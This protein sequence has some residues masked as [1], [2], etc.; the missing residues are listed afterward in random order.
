MRKDENP[1]QNLGNQLAKDC[2]GVSVTVDKPKNPSGVWFLD[3][4]RDGHIVNVQWQP[5]RGFG[6][7]S[8]PGADYGEGADEIYDDSDAVRHRVLSLLLSRGE[9]SPPAAVRLSQLRRQLGLS[10]IEIAERLSVQ[11]G[12]VSRMERRG[13]MKVSSLREYCQS[14][15]GTLKLL[16]QFPNGSA[17]VIQLEDEQETV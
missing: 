10:Q 6:V 4:V 7:S 15:G 17:K 11:Q 9:T 8:S 5:Q 2:P 3:I 16:A 13:D 12:A 14:L 1:I